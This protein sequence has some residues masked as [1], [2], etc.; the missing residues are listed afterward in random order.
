MS[1]LLQKCFNDKIRYKIHK[2]SICENFLALLRT[3][4][5]IVLISFQVLGQVLILFKGKRF[6][7]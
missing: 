7:N 5:M 2:S 6:R 4:K 3:Y 1:E